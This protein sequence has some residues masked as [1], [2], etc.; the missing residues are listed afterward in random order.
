M[1]AS[2]SGLPCPVCAGRK[3]R[4]TDSRKGYSY[5]VVSVRR[6]RSCQTCGARFTTHELNVDELIKSSDLQASK[7]DLLDMLLQEDAGFFDAMVRFANA[8]KEIKQ[9]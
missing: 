7:S 1:V 5:G 9:S 4:V 6:R 2:N 3:N 8:I